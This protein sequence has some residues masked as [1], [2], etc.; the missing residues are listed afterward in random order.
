MGRAGMQGS[1]RRETKSKRGFTAGCVCVFGG[2]GCESEENMARSGQSRP[3]AIRR[4]QTGC[5]IASPLFLNKGIY[6]LDKTRDS[7]VARE[8]GGGKWC[9]WSQTG[10]HRRDCHVW[11]GVERRMCMTMCSVQDRLVLSVSVRRW[12]VPRVGV[13]GGVGWGVEFVAPNRKR[14]KTTGIRVKST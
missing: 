2:L 7:P 4:A 5:Y 10:M 11:V 6:S 3:R 9:P 1:V 14:A 8:S 13:G 12:S